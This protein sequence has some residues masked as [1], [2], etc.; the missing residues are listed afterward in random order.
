ML[1]LASWGLLLGAFALE[2]SLIIAI[3]AAVCR[4]TKRP[5]RQRAI[6]QTVALAGILLCVAE[7]AGVRGRIPHFFP[8]RSSRWHLN[9]TLVASDDRRSSEFELGKTNNRSAD[10]ENN[11]PV[12]WPGWIWLGGTVS[13]LL[14]NV[15]TRLWLTWERE[16]MSVSETELW[17]SQLLARLGAKEVSIRI[18]N[19]VQGPVAFGFWRPT[20]AVPPNFA[21][22]F[23]REQREVMLAHESAHLVLRDPI[24]LALFDVLC[25]LVWWHPLVWW[26]RRS[27][28]RVCE[29]AADEASALLPAGPTTLAESL[30]LFGRELSLKGSIAGIAVGGKDSP[31]ELNLRVR[32]LLTASM[33]WQ[34]LSRW[35]RWMPRVTAVCTVGFL[36]TL[37]LQSA[38]PTPIPEALASCFQGGRSLVPAAQ[39]R[40]ASGQQVAS[41]ALRVA[42]Q[43][44]R[45]LYKCEPFTAG[46]S[47]LWTD[48]QWVWKDRRAF[49]SGDIEALVLLASDLSTQ[50]V[51]V[52]L[53]DS[54]MR[55]PVRVSPQVK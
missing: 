36:L 7:L 50:S 48:G 49:G 51:Q 9:V 20:I 15:A 27:F 3:V 26:A 1:S 16:R 25:A 34:P 6:W 13:F 4:F 42:N 17:A 31:S 5:R 14:L 29:T 37:P 53:L 52:V 11:G 23:S 47:A 30:V 43:Q 41:L 40:R 46:A 8:K 12:R 2:L 24:C 10:L 44:A 38:F 45:A 19:R 32:A 18:W 28:R 21:Q 55:T 54:Q 33:Q 22:R 35:S 39:P